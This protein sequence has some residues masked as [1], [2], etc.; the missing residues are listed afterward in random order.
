MTR[1]PM[2]SLKNLQTRAL[3]KLPLLS[4]SFNRST[5]HG[6]HAHINIITDLHTKPFLC[7]R[8][9]AMR[10]H[11]PLIL[12][13]SLFVQS[14]L[15]VFSGNPPFACDAS[16][17]SIQNYAFCKPTLSI[18]QRTQDL[19]SRLTLDERIAQLVDV[20]PPI[21]RLGVPGYKWWS[22]SLHGVSSGGRGIHFDGP[23][24]A[25]TSFPQVI[26]TAATFN[27]V[28]WY[29]IGQVMSYKFPQY[30]RL[31]KTYIFV[32]IFHYIHVH[33]LT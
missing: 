31:L 9:L 33:C 6:P 26:L 14:P 23:I 15:L 10:F 29:Q 28:L 25:A 21:E 27:P 8:N 32:L 1:Q 22:E 4:L 2:I 11:T 3:S 20:A 5:P 24:K 16:D 12:L 13:F 18:K 30:L 17:P 19:V 7:N